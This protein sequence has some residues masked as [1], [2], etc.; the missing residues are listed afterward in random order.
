[1]IGGSDEEEEAESSSG[2]DEGDSSEEEAKVAAMLEE[3]EDDESVM[4]VEGE[5]E[6]RCYMCRKGG[7]VVCCD[8]CS[9]VVHLKCAGLKKA[10]NSWEC[11]NC[12]ERKRNKG[13]RQGRRK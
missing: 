4:E 13:G 1:M 2:E 8:G 6:T 10:P 12:K 5:W 11:N 9:H 3:E 7:N